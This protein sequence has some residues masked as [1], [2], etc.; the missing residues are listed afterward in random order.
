VLGA[1][2]ADGGAGIE[3]YHGGGAAYDGGTR[4]EWRRL[5]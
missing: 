4:P 2:G 5:H 3:N 1:E